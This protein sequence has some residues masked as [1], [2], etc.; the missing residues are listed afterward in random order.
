MTSK[1]TKLLSTLARVVR[2]AGKGEGMAIFEDPSDEDLED[3]NLMLQITFGLYAVPDIDS[4]KYKSLVIVY[5]KSRWVT[6]GRL[7]G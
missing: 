4:G 5:S 2:A 1:T 3:A 6:R 7:G